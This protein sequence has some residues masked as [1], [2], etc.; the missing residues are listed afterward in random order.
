MMSDRVLVRAATLALQLT[1]IGAA[2]SAQQPA[3][4]RVST[5]RDS[6]QR[7][8]VTVES[9]PVEQLMRELVTTRAME[10][11]VARALREASAGERADQGRA[12]QLRRE[13][14]S[15][16]RRSAGLATAIRMQ[17][18]RSTDAQPDGYLGVTFEQIMISRNNDEPAV[19]QLG[20]RPTIASVE[21]GSPADKAG[22]KAGDLVVTIGG[23][24]AHRLR[25]ESILKPGARVPVRVQREGTTHEFAVVVGKRP[26]D[27]GGTTCTSVDE[28]VG[29]EAPQVMTFQRRPAGT[30]V[31]PP[32]PPRT[33]DEPQVVPGF[34]LSFMS[35]APSSLGGATMVVVDDGWR[36]SLG[37]EKGIV[38]TSVARNS[39]AFESGLRSADVIT[40]VD[41]APVVNVRSVLRA[42]GAS[43][44]RSVKLTVIR[45]R[46]PITL[47]FRMAR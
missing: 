25:L 22:L 15:I 32:M 29:P 36:E 2:A 26:D 30:V 33:P 13:L 44:S 8:R 3:R 27:Y 6:A 34:A 43:E 18:T 11:S 19:Y 35:S 31:R 42:V 16:A 39:P 21:P 47:T 37:V 10:E 1:V 7:L 17:C 38:V 40:A 5:E 46:K 41:D 9:V 28:F 24:D 14:E 23:E 4:V 20:V 45:Q 12:A